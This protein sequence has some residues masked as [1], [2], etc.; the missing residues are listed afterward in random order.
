MEFFEKFKVAGLFV[1]DRK[2]NV[3][4]YVSNRSRF[5]LQREPENKYD[6]NAVLVK[7]PV[8]GGQYALDIGHVPRE[9]AARIAPLMDDGSEFCAT[10]RAKIMNEKTGKLIDLWLNLNSLN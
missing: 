5:V 2:K 6:K 7:L 8:R 1:G 4:R 9:L 3:M 10:F